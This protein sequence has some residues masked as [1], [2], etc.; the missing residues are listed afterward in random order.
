MWT[1]AIPALCILAHAYLVIIFLPGLLREIDERGFRWHTSF[2]LFGVPS[3]TAVLI[4]N[5]ILAHLSTVPTWLLV[6]ALLTI[7]ALIVAMVLSAV[8]LHSRRK[9]AA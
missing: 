5:Y 2:S 9:R 4:A 3:L 1:Y 8:A 6:V 7:D